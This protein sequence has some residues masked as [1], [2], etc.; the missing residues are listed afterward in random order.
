MAHEA[1]LTIFSMFS[2]IA[3]AFR[4]YHLFHRNHRAGPAEGLASITQ[5]TLA[6]AIVTICTL[7]LSHSRCL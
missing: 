5:S 6:W 7:T 2:W 3:G 4:P 1:C